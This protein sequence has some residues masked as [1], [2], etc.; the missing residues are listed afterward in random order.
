MSYYANGATVRQIDA[1][2]FAAWVTANNPKAAGWTLIADPPSARHTW[3]GSAWVG[4]SLDTLKA[5]RIE[6]DREEC[7]R[8]LVEH[9]GDALEQGSRFAGGYGEIGAANILAGT[10]AARAAS[11]VARDAILAIQDGPNA[12]Q[13]LEAVTV[14]WPVLP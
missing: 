9:Y 8:R 7:R 3:S 12:I 14:A 6:A 5:E 11:N 10:I 13:Q 1:Q 4:P 2:L